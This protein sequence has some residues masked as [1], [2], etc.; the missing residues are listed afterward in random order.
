M[1]RETKKRLLFYAIEKMSC[2]RRPS[3]RT[4]SIGI[5]F[6]SIIVLWMLIVFVYFTIPLWT[7]GHNA[8]PNVFDREEEAVICETAGGMW[9]VDTQE[10]EPSELDWTQT[11][12][13]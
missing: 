9:C 11:D 13:E 2:D 7:C 12:F 6:E 3:E 1:V 5:T 8:H 10:Q 4:L